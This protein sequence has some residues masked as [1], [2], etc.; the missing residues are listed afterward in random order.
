MTHAVFSIHV[1]A[2][3]YDGDGFRV[4]PG[5]NVISAEPIHTAETFDDAESW[6]LGR[7][8]AWNTRGYAS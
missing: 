5:G 8:E 6:R 7:I 1:P 3:P 4:V 2:S